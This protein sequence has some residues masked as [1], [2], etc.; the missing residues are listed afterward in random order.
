M[1]PLQWLL[2]GFRGVV[3]NP[4]FISSQNVVQKLISFLFVAR[5]KL[6]R[7]THPF[8]LVIVR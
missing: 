3:E 7:G 4:C 2:L 1:V 5:E 8:R 6:Q